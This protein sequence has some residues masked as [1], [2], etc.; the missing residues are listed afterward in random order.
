MLFC[1][2]ISSKFLESVEEKKACLR[3][4]KLIGGSSSSVNDLED[5]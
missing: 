5:L 2:I 1:L 4:T 3:S